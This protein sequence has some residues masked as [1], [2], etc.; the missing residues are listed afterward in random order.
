MPGEVGNKADAA[1]H[2][3]AAEQVLAKLGAD[4]RKGL[5]QEDA[6]ARLERFGPNEL[7]AEDPVPAWQKFLAQ[8]KD[9]LV[10]LLLVATAISAALW[11][12]ERES[13]L[14]Y[15]AIAIFAVVL[16]N[17]IMGYVQES[18]AESAVAALRQMA[19]AHAHVIRE[20]ERQSV[21]ATEIVPGDI[22]V[23]EEGDTIP[24]DAR[25][26]QSTALQT[27]EAALTGES[28]PVSKDIAPVAADAGL[29]DRTNMLFAG[30][31]ATYGHGKAVVTATG[32]QT[33]MG[34]IAGLLTAAPA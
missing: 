17:A 10:I 22:I 12:V 34:H 7:T 6:R 8:F 31:A 27:A 28:L 3:L 23:I 26:I 30:T 21:A 11:L 14:P 33:E 9:V 25:L 2:A 29:G 13:A 32:M 4:E 19:A 16:L 5:S 1:P 20:G 15:E 18:R 24:A